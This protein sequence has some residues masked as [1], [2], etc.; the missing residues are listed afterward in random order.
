MHGAL[1]RTL[2]LANKRDA[3]TKT[4]RKLE[5]LARERYVS[6]FEFASIHFALGQLDVAFQWLNKARDER[7]FELIA[8]RV[9][10]RFDPLRD[11]PQFSAVVGQIGFDKPVG[12]LSGT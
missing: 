2:A 7:V 6:P 9:D 8:I 10:P 4:L 1:G 11:D 3:A 5:T 12:D